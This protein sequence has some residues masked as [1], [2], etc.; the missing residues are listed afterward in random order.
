MSVKT[1]CPQS[2]PSLTGSRV[3][4]LQHPWEDETRVDPVL[5]RDDQRKRSVGFWEKP[6]SRLYDSF[7]VGL[8][9]IKLIVVSNRFDLQT[10]GGC[11][12]M[13]GGTEIRQTN[14]PHVGK[15]NLKG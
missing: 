1:D 11:R 12:A 6:R 8:P 7:R 13:Y 4:T 9:N 2:F 15:W 3:V 14:A 10:A 5:S